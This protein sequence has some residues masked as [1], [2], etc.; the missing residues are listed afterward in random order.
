MNTISKAWLQGL[1]GMLIFSATL[2]ATRAGLQSFDPQFL[3]WARAAIAGVLA[4]MALLVFKSKLP[5]KQDAWPLL[6]VIIGT[7]IGFPLLT[8]LA[9]QYITS[10]RAL[11][12]IGMLPMMT[13]LFGV[14]RAGERPNKVFWLFSI[15]GAVLVVSFALTQQQSGSLTGDLLMLCAVAICGLGYAEGANLTKRF[16]GWQTVCWA[17]ALCWPLSMLLAWVHQPESWAGVTTPA[18]LGLAYVSLFSMLI[19]FVFWY[20]GLA[21]GGIASVGQLQ[22][23]QP[24]F[25]MLL[26]SLLLHETIT[27]SMVLVALAVVICVA[28]AKWAA[29]PMREPTLPDK[30][31]CV[32]TRQ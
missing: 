24:F 19:G 25:G 16:G 11:V 30:G 31:V 7:V 15:T 22:L 27:I 23:V 4:I 3:T 12:F 20:R 9:L 18:W 5:Q 10:A 1:I 26:A 32:S 29:S 14:L 6:A 13:A 21:Q 28:G 2:P 8:G 17:L